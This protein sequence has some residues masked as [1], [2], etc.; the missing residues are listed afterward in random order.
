MKNTNQSTI[1]IINS[2]WSI[3]ELKDAA[4]ANWMQ[5]LISEFIADKNCRPYDW[6][7]SE[8]LTDFEKATFIYAC[9]KLQKTGA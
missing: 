7:M 8:K 9:N 3:I 1:T 5:R 6:I 4:K 2:E